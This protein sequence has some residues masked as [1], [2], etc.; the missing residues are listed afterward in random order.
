MGEY[1]AAIFLR[2]ILVNNQLFL[3]FKCINNY[4]SS[5]LK[6]NVI[7]FFEINEMKI[8]LEKSY[9]VFTL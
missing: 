5:L 7:E 3:L 8:S 6:N 4:T 9:F 1:Y 2:V